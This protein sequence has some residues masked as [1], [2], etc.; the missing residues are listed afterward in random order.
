MSDTPIAIEVDCSTGIATERP[1]TPEEIAA[2]DAAVAQAQ[3][4]A[5]ARDAAD[6][7]K[8]AA[9]DAALAKL[10]TLGLTAEEVAALLG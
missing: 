4:D 7:A 5:A 2:R 8:A 10:A 9:K 1:L 3:A 6:V